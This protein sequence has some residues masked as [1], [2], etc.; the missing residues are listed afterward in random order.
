MLDLPKAVLNPG[1]Q[2]VEQRDLRLDLSTQISQDLPGIGLVWLFSTAFGD[3][4]VSEWH[5]V[6]QR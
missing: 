2:R 1:S 4:V 3:F 6:C 5:D